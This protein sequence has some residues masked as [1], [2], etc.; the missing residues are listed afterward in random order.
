[1]LYFILPSYPLVDAK[2]DLAA[3]QENDPREAAQWRTQQEA[4]AEAVQQQQN[5]HELAFENYRNNLTLEGY[6]QELQ[7]KKAR[8]RDREAMHHILSETNAEIAKLR[9]EIA[10]LCVSRGDANRHL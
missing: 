10:R 9:T 8:E 4:A 2:R 6:L 5:E 1:M 7:D 3:M